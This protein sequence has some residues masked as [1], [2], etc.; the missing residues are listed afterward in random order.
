MR[1]FVAPPGL[2]A[3]SKYAVDIKR[4]LVRNDK[5]FEQKPYSITLSSPSPES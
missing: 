3:S 2:L 1:G 5:V 4:V